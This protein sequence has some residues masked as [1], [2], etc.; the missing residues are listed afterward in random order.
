GSSRRS[1]GCSAAE[2]RRYR[3]RL[4]GPLLDR[5][6]LCVEM[7]ECVGGLLLF[8]EP[9]TDPEADNAGA[10]ADWR[11]GS[12]ATALPA[13]QQRLAARHGLP[14][15]TTAPLLTR[16]RGYGLTDTALAHLDGVRAPLG[17]SVRGV[18]RCARV[19]RTIAALDRTATVTA[20][21]VS[22]A[23]TF[24]REALAAFQPA[25]SDML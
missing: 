14:P 21:H 13:A 2:V 8:T 6:D 16:L 18:L 15:G 7:P 17:L 5:F 22:E 20:G 11:N 19:A 1:C 3:T 9:D 4:S 12:V 25:D 23:L 10:T 24:R